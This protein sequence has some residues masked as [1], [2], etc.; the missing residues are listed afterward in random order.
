MPKSVY[1]ETT[2]PSYLAA[3][4]SRDLIRAARQQITLEWWNARRHEF[5]I[6]VSQFVVDEAS[7]G[8][9]ELARRRLELL[10]DVPVL[11]VVA[12]AYELAETLIR[13]GVLPKKAVTDALHV[14]MA[15][16][17]DV[18]ILL[19]WNCTHLANPELLGGVQRVIWSE[20]HRPPV[21]CT[22]GEMM[23]E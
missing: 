14:A 21:I 2:I 17:H 15:T 22:P 16:V 7:D 10:G 12:P 19:T 18:D 3:P 23:G 20:G 8:D 9:P 5:E 13:E 6:C 1:L 4:R 11:E